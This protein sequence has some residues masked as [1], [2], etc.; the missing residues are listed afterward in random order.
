MRATTL[1]LLLLGWLLAET[2]VAGEPMPTVRLVPRPELLVVKVTPAPGHHLAADLPLRARVDDGYFT[3]EVNDPA[4]PGSG[5]GRLRLPLV[6]ES[7]ITAW[8]VTVEGATCADDGTTCV[9]F[10][11]VAALGRGE[12]ATALAPSPGRA[13]RP[14]TGSPARA[15]E[16]PRP[17]VGVSEGA[18]PILYDFFATWCPPCDR[19]RDEFL[20]HPDWKEV[21]D[22]YEVRSIDADDPTSFA[23]KDRYR[24]G[25]YPTV[26]LASPRGEVLARVVGFPG[27][28]ELA[29]RLDAALQPPPEAGCAAAV[30][31]ARQQHA[32]DDAEGAWE[33]LDAGCADPKAFPDANSRIFAFE[34]AEERKDSSRALAFALSAVNE[35]PLGVSARLVGRAGQL[36]DALERPDEAARLRAG[37]EARITAALGDEGRTPEDRIA[38]AD[39]LY[40]QATWT[41]GSARALHLAAA[42]ELAT[43]ILVRESRPPGPLP[44]A[45]LA[46]SDRLKHHEGLVHDLIYLLRTAE[47]HDAVGRLYGAMLQL[48]PEAFTWHYAQAGWLLSRGAAD[49][50]EPAA[51]A[52]LLHSYGDMTL[53]AAKRLA[54]VLI[55]R[56]RPGEALAEIDKALGA[57]PPAEEHVRTWRYRNDLTMLRDTLAPAKPR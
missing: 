8:T 44:D 45:V 23:L 17:P 47:A 6:R 52:A 19:L 24:V 48:Y 36:L 15:P 50:A 14:Q 1:P 29:D 5:E 38:L 22:R 55:A 49:K 2:A 34:L 7:R 53:R 9:P 16:P 20:E 42:E 56:G 35:S 51:R 33:T 4:P 30:R 25:G 31:T 27:A 10:H 39:A 32:R 37:L 3:F 46:L 11:V 12:L 28:R 43:A 41:P 40:H 18:K 26:V 21:L 57:P 13:P 54:E